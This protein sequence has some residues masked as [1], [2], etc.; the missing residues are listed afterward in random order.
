MKI[1][2][3]PSSQELSYKEN[4]FVSAFCVDFLARPED[5]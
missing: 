3:S 1:S 2:T 4:S 5:P